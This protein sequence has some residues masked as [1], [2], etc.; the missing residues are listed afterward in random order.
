MAQG[1]VGPSRYEF[2]PAIQEV[3]VLI[4]DHFVRFGTAFLLWIFL[5]GHLM[6]C[7]CYRYLQEPRS[8][9]RLRLSLMRSLMSSSCLV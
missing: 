5:Q 4:G 8:L 1:Y 6:T 9:M 2:G 3:L 7:P